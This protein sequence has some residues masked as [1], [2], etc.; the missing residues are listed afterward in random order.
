[1]AVKQTV[2]NSLNAADQG[3]SS[4]EVFSICIC[5]F[6]IRYLSGDVLKPTKQSTLMRFVRQRVTNGALTKQV[7]LMNK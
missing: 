3:L 1:M 4:R 6:S 7:D 5:V 2:G